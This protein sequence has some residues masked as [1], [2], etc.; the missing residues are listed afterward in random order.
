MGMFDYIIIKDPL[1][2]NDEIRQWGIDITKQEFQTKSLQRG[3][4]EY[5]IQDGKLF[6]KKYKTEEWVDDDTEI[7]GGYMKYEGPYLKEIEDFHG[8]INFYMFH[9]DDTWRYTVDYHSIFTRGK[10]EEI[11]LIKWKR[12]DNVE[13]SARIKELIAQSVEQGY[14][15]YNRFIFHTSAWRATRNFICRVIYKI[16]Q[17][18]GSIRI[19][20][21]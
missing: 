4:R 17:K 9:S 5:T 21:P 13:S 16:E 15:W 11:K 14:K 1:P 10:L 3:L 2:I 19:N 12:E 7:V 18:L 6:V 20:L 8:V